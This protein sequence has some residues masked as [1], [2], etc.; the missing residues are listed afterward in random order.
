MKAYFLQYFIEDLPFQRLEAVF[1]P[2]PK[3]VGLICRTIC[4]WNNRDLNLLF[5]RSLEDNLRGKSSTETAS[6]RKWE[7]C[8][9]F[10]DGAFPTAHT[11]II[12]LRVELDETCL[13]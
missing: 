9:S 5:M 12:I 10:E 13:D 2:F 4:G 6:A 3:S 1:V 8:K 7:I 11:I